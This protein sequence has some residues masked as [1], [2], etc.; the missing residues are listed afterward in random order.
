MGTISNEEILKSRIEQLTKLL[1]NIGSKRKH[2]YW[3]IFYLIK[4]ANTNPDKIADTL[5]NASLVWGDRPEDS[6][7]L[8]GIYYTH[9][10]KLLDEYQNQ[11]VDFIPAE[12]TV[13]KWSSLN[14]LT[15]VSE[16]SNKLRPSI[17]QLAATLLKRYMGDYESAKAWLDFQSFGCNNLPDFGLTFLGRESELEELR[18]YFTAGNPT[19]VC[20]TK[21]HEPQPNV[22]HAMGGQGKTALARAYAR[23]YIDEYGTVVFLDGSTGNA[24][25]ALGELLTSEQGCGLP[26]F[27]GEENTQ[28]QP[29]EYYF[30]LLDG[31]H[32]QRQVL[33]IVDDLADERRLKEIADQANGQK[34]HLLITRREANLKG[35]SKMKGLKFIRLQ[36]LSAR[37][38]GDVFLDRADL[39][40][41]DPETEQLQ[42]IVDGKLGR[43]ALSI[44]LVAGYWAGRSGE[45]L[46]ILEAELDSGIDKIS[47]GTT[48]KDYPSSLIAAFNLSFDSLPEDY[49]LALMLLGLFPRGPVSTHIF[50]K[51]CKKLNPNLPQTGS[52][53][54]LVS[55]PEMLAKAVR[56]DLLQYAKKEGIFS[57]HE[58]VYD[59]LQ[60]RLIEYGRYNGN[61]L[62]N[63][64]IIAIASVGAGLVDQARER[65]GSKDKLRIDLRAVS[66]ALIPTIMQKRSYFPD[67]KLIE[68][69]S[70][71]WLENFRFHQ[72]VYDNEILDEFYDDIKSL[73]EHLE[74]AGQYVGPT[75]IVFNK[76]LGHSHYANPSDPNNIA[77]G[78]QR[79]QGA[80]DEIEAI[81]RDPLRHGIPQSTLEWYYIFLLDHMLNIK[82]KAALPI[83]ETIVP[84]NRRPKLKTWINEVE[85]ML[86]TSLCEL[87]E[88][89]DLTDYVFLLRAAHYWG[90]RGNQDQFT[91]LTRV[92][93]HIYDEL[94]EQIGCAARD[95]FRKAANLRLLS[96][97]LSY[98]S[99]LNQGGVNGIEDIAIFEPWV[100]SHEPE[101]EISGIEDFTSF[102][103]GM[104]DIAHQARQIN[105]IDI[106]QTAHEIVVAKSMEKIEVEKMK[107]SFEWASKLW[108]MPYNSQNVLPIRYRLWLCS[109]S[110]VMTLLTDFIDKQ[111]LTPWGEIEQLLIDD[112]DATQKRYGIQYPYVV[113]QQKRETKQLWAFL[114][115]RANR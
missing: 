111:I 108:S 80:L 68:T 96:L 11:S 8:S 105:W 4:V 48:L 50:K 115:E 7:S 13:G 99:W 61:T 100:L 31:R 29:L 97:R 64:F 81:T 70:K 25:S 42:A 65:K 75:K 77:A 37:D 109:S 98:R 82:S 78:E 112:I 39:K 23:R 113:E 58:V 54:A 53:R 45:N 67:S 106:I 9:Y 104:N 22:I 63:E 89:Q 5:R 114:D 2:Y 72:F 20:I 87:T 79:F 93:N 15:T 44:C 91:F 1:I 46:K 66:G 59:L 86:P 41:C 17:R 14:A 30:R 28:E 74:E 18:N 101:T 40:G 76:M 38:A 71:F 26:I 24:T 73:V 85:Q 32:L 33:I 52:L 56:H 62:R 94:T 47:G 34:V 57:F 27:N 3:L 6:D 95:H 88:I 36:P 102:H 110:I 10:K 90:H 16:W 19:P 51:V 55:P 84:I 43:H 107:Q 60:D 21:E 83:K 49:K 92:T 103:Q 12:A 69:S 35:Q